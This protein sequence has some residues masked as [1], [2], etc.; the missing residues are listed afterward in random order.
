MIPELVEYEENGSDARSVSYARIVALLIE[1]VKEQQR[2]IDVLAKRN[3]DLENLR[4]RLE[5]LE[6]AAQNAPAVGDPVRP[7]VI[8]FPFE[9]LPL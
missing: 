1:A 7:W 2:E 3:D 4:D 8:Q 9:D 5:A 6:S